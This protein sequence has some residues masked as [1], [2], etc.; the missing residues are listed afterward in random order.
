MLILFQTIAIVI[1]II[2]HLQFHSIQ[3]QRL[4]EKDEND[5]A[6][7]P[8]IVHY[9]WYNTKKTELRFDHA[10]SVLSAVKYI[11]P[12][13]IHFHTNNEPSGKYYKMLKNLPMFKVMVL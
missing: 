12:D 4:E 11:K 5:T 2:I 13:A 1:I 6:S 9:I 3:I 10:L 7:I 8:N